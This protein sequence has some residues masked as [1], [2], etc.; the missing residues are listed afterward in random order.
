MDIIEERC[1]NCAKLEARIA[2]LEG[3]LRSIKARLGLDSTTSNQPP[4]KD[5]PWKPKSERQKSERSSGGQPGHPG[6]TLKFSDEPDEIQPLPLT[7]ECG[8]GHP[9]ETVDVTHH[10]ARQVHDL[11]EL[12]L[13]ITEYQAEVKICPQCGCQG[14]AS[15]PGH[16]P[17]QVQYGP[18]LHALTTYLN[19]VHFVPL[20]RVTQLTDA[21][22][23]ASMSD[24]TVALNINLASERLQLFEEELKQGLRQQAVLH[25]DETGAKVN[26]K[27]H[28]CHVACCAGGTLYTVHEQRGFEA[29]KAAGVL[30][31]F[32]GVVVHDAWNTYFRLPGAHAL[33][34]AHLLRELRKL[35]E[36]DGQ[37]WAGELRRELQQ[38]YHLQKSGTLTEQQKKAFY[39]RFDELV[40]AGLEANPVQEPI[41]KQRGKTKQLP[42]RNLASRCQQHRRA[43]LLF[44]ERPDVPLDNNQAERDIRMLCV[45]RKVSGG[46]RSVTGGEAFCRIRSFVST[47]QKQGLS[48]WEGLV[49]VFRGVLP[50]LDFSC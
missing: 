13:H 17:G 27:L 39:K 44:L 50:K 45:K 23:G 47:L 18:Q 42:G 11:P 28:W 10:L 24:G 15:F 43:M 3:E 16:V 30:P 22:F 4:S 35:D 1:P 5:L 9:W 26:G 2:E 32:E 36:H 46:F 14:Q 48:V 6:K 38:V 29:L 25:A 31:D 41:P 49:G 37:L 19:V 12:R 8:C 21:L 34:N 20:E 33:C 40:E 7:G